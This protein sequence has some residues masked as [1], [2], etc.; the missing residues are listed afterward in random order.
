[1]KV[2][3][4]TIGNKVYD[5]AVGSAAFLCESFEYMK[6][7]KNL[8]TK[9]VKLLQKNTFYGKEKKSLAYIIGVMN[10][11]FHGINSPNIVLQS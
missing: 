6:N 2:V 3:A 4:P 10:M 8:T 7:S 11:I 5:G 1:M 9:D